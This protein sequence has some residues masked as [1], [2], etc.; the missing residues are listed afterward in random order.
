M[1]KN[2][3]FVLMG[4]SATGKDTLYKKLLEEGQLP[5]KPVVIYTTRPIRQGEIEGEAYH[6]VD[7]ETYE[8]LKAEQKVIEYRDY[9]T[10]HGIWS[11]FTVAD[12]QFTDSQAVLLINTLEG[13]TQILSYFGKE[14]V[15]PLY[16]EVEDG[17]RLT[18]ALCREKSQ[19]EP[20]YEELCRRFLADA[21][22][23]SEEKL[24]AAGIQK[25]FENSNMETC[26][27]ELENAIREV[28]KF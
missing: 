26:L 28:L 22:D 14:R 2:K 21:K 5:I 4:K 13:Y 24:A 27:K 18:R 23:F 7:V 16:V 6:F 1:S 19:S 17:E 15:V 20:K 12:A 10:V 8:R 9:H 3:I 11:Y 25:R